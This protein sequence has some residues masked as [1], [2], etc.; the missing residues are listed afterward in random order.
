VTAPPLLILAVLVGGAVLGGRPPYKNRFSSIGSLYS[1]VKDSEL[2]PYPSKETPADFKVLTAVERLTSF[3]GKKRPLV[4]VCASGG[5]I[6]AAA[7]TSAVLMQLERNLQD[8]PYH[9]KLVCGASGGMVGAGYYVASLVPPERAKRDEKSYHRSDADVVNRRKAGSSTDARDLAEPATFVNSVAEDM[10]S[11]VFKAAIF[12][13][14]WRAFVPCSSRRDRGNIL[15]ETWRLNMG[16]AW[17][18]TFSD[19]IA[20]E[21]SAWRPSLVYSPM[22]VEDGRRVLIS[23][24][25][26]ASLA[27]S[28][29]NYV[30]N[31]PPGSAQDFYSQS[32][33][34]LFRLLPDAWNEL[35]VSTAARMS[36]SFPYLSPAAVLPTNPRRRV[37][38][39]GYY[40]NYGVTV[41]AGWLQDLLMTA[42]GRQALHD[43]VSGVVVI[44]VRDGPSD[45]GIK[46]ETLGEKDTSSSLSRGFEGLT[47]PAEGVGSARN[48]VSLY[49]NDEKLDWLSQ[50]FGNHGFAADFFTNVLFQFNGEASLSWYLT[51][52][53]QRV[54]RCKAEALGAGSD[55]RGL[56]EWWQGRDLSL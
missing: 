14:I 3:D 20:G 34:E 51:Q 39:A 31:T 23:N 2:T 33:F 8:F 6:R 17:K 55:M 45:R 54:I 30:C 9:V 53:E 52:Q 5:G 44:E 24:L 22:M 42:E 32:S 46:K 25:D 21:R 49:R 18:Q 19:L 43:Q 4:I 1:R 29:G 16:D 36:A 41:A 15:E 13:D 28:H 27:T 7:W 56:E 37:V 50:T 48:S 38:D 47:S 35:R 26:L 11:V 12:R 40:D 10:L